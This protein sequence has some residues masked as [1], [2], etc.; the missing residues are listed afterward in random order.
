MLACLKP[1][2]WTL[3]LVN[4]LHCP[5]CGLGRASSSEPIQG[6]RGSRGGL[7]SSSPARQVWPSPRVC[8]YPSPSCSSPPPPPLSQVPRFNCPV[9]APDPPQGWPA[10]SFSCETG[11]QAVTSYLIWVKILHQKSSCPNSKQRLRLFL[12]T[13]GTRTRQARP[14]LSL[15]A[16]PGSADRPLCGWYLV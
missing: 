16:Q 4:C 3:I 5:D 10:V 15:H 1:K 2:C 9:L 8:P 13:T 14:L 12:H 11:V 6:H 7:M